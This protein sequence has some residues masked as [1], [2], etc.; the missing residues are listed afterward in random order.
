MQR[1]EHIAQAST[2]AASRTGAR[3]NSGANP[4][5]RAFGVPT[6]AG[7][8]ALEAELLGAQAEI[9]QL[10]RTLDTTIQQKNA[11]V[12]GYEAMMRELRDTFTQ[13]VGELR[14]LA[15]QEEIDDQQQH[16]DGGE[17]GPR[18]AQQ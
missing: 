3:I 9:E 4:P 1:A 17:R 14:H 11:E 5:P 7:M 8:Q 12:Q 16:E 15:E 2:Q 6:K 18:S 13:G 10:R